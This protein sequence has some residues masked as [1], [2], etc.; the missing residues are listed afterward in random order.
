[1]NTRSKST[2][3]LIEQ[4][5]VIAVFAI[6]AAA[7]ISILASAYFTSEDTRD[8]SNALLVA[9]SAAEAYKATGGDLASVAGIMGGGLDYSDGTYGMMVNYDGNWNV[10]AGSDSVYRLLLMPQDIGS[11]HS[12][13]DSANLSVSKQ[14]GEEIISFPVV[15]RKGS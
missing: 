7:C 10:S 8:M 3:F 14:T 12:S 11:V 6:C 1:M 2:L 15:T 13:L 9:E 4:L 5:I